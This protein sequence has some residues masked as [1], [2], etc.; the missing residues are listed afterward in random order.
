MRVMAAASSSRTLIPSSSC[1]TTSLAA[2][3]PRGSP[4]V[5]ASLRVTQ[6]W[7]GPGIGALRR[8]A[9]TLKSMRRITVCAE[10]VQGGDE[11]LDA[12]LDKAADEA[13]KGAEESKQVWSKSVEDLK[14]EAQRIA[15]STEENANKVIAI[16][17]RNHPAL[18]LFFVLNIFLTAV[19]CNFLCFPACQGEG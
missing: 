7:R 17:L 13:G 16:I 5:I 12:K 19:H 15:D 18:S 1:S 11:P 14:A 10:A 3:S 2:A 6:K 9:V 8:G 4:L